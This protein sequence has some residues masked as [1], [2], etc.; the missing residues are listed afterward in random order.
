MDGFRKELES[1]QAADLSFLV[2]KSV[3]QQSRRDRRNRRKQNAVAVVPEQGAAKIARP[4]PVVRIPHPTVTPSAPAAQP[5]GDHPLPPFVPK[6][7]TATVTEAASAPDDAKASR[8][9]KHV[10]HEWPVV[11][12]ILAGTYFGTLY[13]AEVVAADK[14]L[15]SGKQLVLLDGPAKGR[16]FDSLTKALLVAT[17]KQRETMGLGRSGATNGW[18]FWKVEKVNPAPVP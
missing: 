9:R 11:G 1:L 14:R 6:G 2:P 17:E 18:D 8:K 15:K 12:A 3:P 4:I 13:R 5:A 7:N 10:D 16:R